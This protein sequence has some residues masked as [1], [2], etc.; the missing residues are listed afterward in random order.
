VTGVRVSA[1]IGRGNLLVSTGASKKSEGSVYM[2]D[3][4]TGA[5]RLGM[6][7]AWA[8]GPWPSNIGITDPE[9][10]FRAVEHRDTGKVDVVDL[11][12]GAVRA[13]FQ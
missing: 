8:I 10:K 12:T 7:R 1:E 11:R 5:M 2:V 4:N 9:V 13:L 3:A 6:A